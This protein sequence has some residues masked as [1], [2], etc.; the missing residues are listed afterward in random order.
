VKEKKRER[1]EERKKER[2]RRDS[3]R[4]LSHWICVRL[5]QPRPAPSVF[6]FED[7]EIDAVMAVQRYL[8][9]KATFAGILEAEMAHE[10]TKHSSGT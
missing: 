1:E 5:A 2:T 4:A 10:A 6:L 3:R 9:C 7:S 8:I